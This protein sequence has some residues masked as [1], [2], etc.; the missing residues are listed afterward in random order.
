M[1]LETIRRELPGLLR[2][3]AGELVTISPKREGEMEQVPDTARVVL[4]AIAARVDVWPELEQLG[5]GRD[6][7][8]VTLAQ[9]EHA[10][11]SIET[12][13]LTEKVLTGDQLRRD[14]KEGGALFRISRISDG[15]PGRTLFYLS[16]A[17][18]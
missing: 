7:P 3:M 16:R 9:G 18:K 8:S 13:L 5:G 10:T 12:V 1:D 11:A 17:G 14:P 6:R 4:E 15:G 2:G